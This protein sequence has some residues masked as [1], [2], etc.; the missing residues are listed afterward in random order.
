MPDNKDTPAYP[1]SLDCYG[2]L[3]KYEAFKLAAI[4]G[5][6][7]NPNIVVMRDIIAETG[8]EFKIESFANVVANKALEE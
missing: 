2:G 5:L 3:T 6:M 1:Q 4:Q 7:A 8:I